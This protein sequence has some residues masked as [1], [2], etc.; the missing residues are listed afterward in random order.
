M[1]AG[2][3]RFVVPQGVD[4]PARVSGGN[5]YD[6]RVRDA[7]TRLGWAVLT[8]EVP[9]DAAASALA[10]AR[11]DD[12]VLVDGLV[13][14]RSAAAL[15]AEAER[16]RLVVLAHMVSEAFPD[17]D[18]GAVA[19]ERRALAAAEH[20]IATSRWTRTQLAQRGLVA[21]ARLSVA[22][23][24]TD[25]VPPAHGTRGGSAM[26]CLGVVAPHKGQDVLVEALSGLGGGGWTCT[27][28]G[29]VDAEPAFARRVVGRR[30]EAG[31]RD[32][33]RMPGVLAG[34]A[35]DEALGGA[36]LLVAPSRV[37]AY[38]MVVAD[39]LRRGIPVVASDVGGIPEAVASS[40]AAV[41]V[42]PGDAWAL[43]VALE[44]WVADPALRARLT[45]EAR[46]GRDRL[47]RWT[48]TAAR[49]AAVLEE[50]AR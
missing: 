2:A 19:G 9:P 11:D 16:L 47:P 28:A 49:V 15:E 23:P 20:V 34:A 8:T 5:V 14:G 29:S 43:R 21:P 18:E 7:L 39:A 30:E 37:E 32:R 48:D 41:L 35:L 17:A 46:R 36:D 38:G 25:D 10:S 26:L 13:A 40:E 42:P 44:R 1:S 31:L 6:A 50:V 24:G 45:G 3:V 12:L 27:I 4:D 22:I 33:I